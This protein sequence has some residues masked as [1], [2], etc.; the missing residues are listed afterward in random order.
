[1]P[2]GSGVVGVARCSAARQTGCQLHRARCRRMMRVR[3]QAPCA[4]RPMALALEMGR[5]TMMSAA[6]ALQCLALAAPDRL[7][8]TPAIRGPGGPPTHFN[9]W[10]RGVCI[11]TR[12]QPAARHGTLGA[13]R[14]YPTLGAQGKKLGV[15]IRVKQVD[16]RKVK[17]HNLL[18]HRVGPFRGQDR[19]ALWV[20]GR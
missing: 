5:N 15:M 13:P 2:R 18:R 3:N 12:M 11:G 19:Q 1:M 6:F 4:Q 20:P 10:R 16:I 17:Y 9:D 14:D 7:R 8:H